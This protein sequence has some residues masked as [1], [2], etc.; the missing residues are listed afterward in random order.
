MWGARSAGLS[1][2]KDS[3]LFVSR[4]CGFV[5]PPTRLGSPPEVVKVILTAG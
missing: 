1:K 4:G 2:T 3:Y 5:G